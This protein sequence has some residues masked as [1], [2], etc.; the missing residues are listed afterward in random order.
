MVFNKIGLFSSY[1]LFKNMIYPS[2]EAPCY[3][4]R[5]FVG[6]AGHGK[7]YSAIKELLYY[8]NKYPDIAVISNIDINGIDVIELKSLDDLVKDYPNGAIVLIDELP[9]LFSSRAWKNFPRNY[10]EN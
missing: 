4:L 9:T 3:G 6:L 2:D 7:T 8:K 10:L 1:S 5:G